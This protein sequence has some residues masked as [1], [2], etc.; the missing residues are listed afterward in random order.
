[1]GGNHDHGLVAGWID[2]RLE[3]EPSGFLGARAAHRAARRRARWRRRSPTPPRPARRQRR[4]P[5]RV[6]ARRRVRHPRPLLRPARHRPDLRAPRRPARWPAGSCGCPS[7]GA[8]P[9][10][11]EAVLAPLYAWMNALTQRS[12]RAVLS[13]GAGASARAWVALAGERA[14]RRPLRAAALGAGYAAAVAGLNAAGL[15]PLE[16]DLSGAGAAARLPARHRGGD[17]AARR[18]A[19]RTCSGAT[20]TAPARG[21]GDDPAEWTAPARH[22]HPQHGL[23]GLP[24]PLPLATARTTRPTGPAPP[25]SSRTT[26]RRGWSGCWA[27]GGTGSWSHPRREAGHVDVEPG[28]DGQLE[29]RPRC[30]AGARPA[31]GSRARRSRRARR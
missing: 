22:A 4:L 19:R 16:R 13:A 3:T 14:A 2:G 17:R 24:A 10:D 9:D 8:T 6:A 18:S 26:R 7:T 31:G 5:G 30:G 28:A 21:R 1:M 23:V 15:G 25:S 11:Y 12:D 20:P 27:T 29:R